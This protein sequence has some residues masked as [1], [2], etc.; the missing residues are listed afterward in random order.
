M[1]RGTS[2]RWLCMSS[3][4]YRKA[5][6]LPNS[7]SFSASIS[8][9]QRSEKWHVALEAALTD[10]FHQ[11]CARCDNPVVLVLAH[12]RRVASGNGLCDTVIKKPAQISLELS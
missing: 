2:G 1:R 5:R 4:R 8:V 11:R 10:A 6:F 7:V 9:C 12:A 3:H